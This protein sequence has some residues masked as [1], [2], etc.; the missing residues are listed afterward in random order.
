M[1]LPHDVPPGETA[2]ITAEARAPKKVGNYSLRLQMEDR[3]LGP[4][5]QILD[6]RLTVK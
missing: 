6:T 3:A 2:T 4:F 1:G 5:G